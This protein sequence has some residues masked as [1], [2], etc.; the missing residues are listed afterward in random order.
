MT[1][2]NTQHLEKIEALEK[3]LAEYRSRD[4]LY[5]NFN[6]FFNETTDLICIASLE[7]YFLKVNNAFIK[8]LGFSEEELLAK[9]FI[10]YVHPD[11]IEKTLQEIAN[12]SKGINTVD[13]SN[14]YVKKDGSFIY[15][16]WISTINQNT[17]IEPTCRLVDPIFGKSTSI[18]I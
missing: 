15:L 1:Y 18:E 6:Y 10:N 4:N 9:Q 2:S 14:R 12:L 5:N 7:G 8:T 3:E 16:Q 17:N 13:F 11:D